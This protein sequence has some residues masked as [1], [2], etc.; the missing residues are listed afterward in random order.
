MTWHAS[1]ETLERYAGGSASPAE[2]ASL[3][4]HLFECH[5]CRESLV[6]VTPRATKERSAAILAGIIDSVDAPQPTFTEWIARRLGV[7]DH[8]ARLLGVTPSLRTSWLA[9][10]VVTLAFAV[11]A[12]DVR[13]GV[14]TFLIVAP[15]LPVAGVAAAFSRRVDA[16]A[17]MS[18]VAST[19]ASW[20]LLIRTV[21]V[22]ATTLLFTGVAA[23]LLPGNE[24]EAAAWLLP[25]LALSTSAVALSTR[26]DPIISSAALAGAWIC[27]CAATFGPIA[28]RIGTIGSGSADE[29]ITRSLLFGPTGQIVLGLVAAVAITITVLQR[30]SIDIGSIA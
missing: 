9:G 30:E 22:L 20:L 17:E 19:R 8:V 4:P 1:T 29:L 2:A 27:S 7:A 18:A 13:G 11:V 3:E 28:R 21:A 26:I 12:S 6:A 24:W 15:L 10:I 14:A 5:Q 16:S 25:S 23:L